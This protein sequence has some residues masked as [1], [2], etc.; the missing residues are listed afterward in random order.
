MDES[1]KGIPDV[2]LEVWQC[3]SAGR[4]IHKMDRHDAPVD[5][6]FLGAGRAMTDKNGKYHFY[7]IKPGAYPWGNHRNAWRPAHI[8]FSLF[9][10]EIGTRLITQM[11][12]PNDPLFEFDPIFN[13]VPQHAQELLISKFNLNFTEPEFA[14]GYEFNIVLRGNNLTPFE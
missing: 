3:N 6:N 10:R 11:Y 7:T 14:L 12:F 8:H 4:Y 2:L 13:S 1:G 9:G 5:P